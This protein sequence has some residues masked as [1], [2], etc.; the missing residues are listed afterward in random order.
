MLVH[1]AEEDRRLIILAQAGDLDALNELVERHHAW[2]FHLAQRMLWN[3]EDAEDA[4]QEIFI[5]AVTRLAAFEGRSEFRTWLYRIAGNHLL[6]RCRAVKSFDG[7]AR[8]LSDLPDRDLADPNSSRLEASV[9]VEEAKLACTAGI[10]LCLAPRQRMAFLL[11][12]VLGVQDDVGGEVL[13]TS[14]VNF[15]QLL[16]RARRELYGFLQRR[17]GLA[18]PANACRCEN[19]ALGFIALKIVDPERLPFSAARIGEVRRVAADRLAEIRE[20]ERG[21]AEIFRDQPLAPPP[22]QAARLRRLFEQTG[23]QKSMGLNS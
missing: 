5:K 4:T 1:D 13:N 7:M 18:N 14:P 19:K 23:I 11:G 15:R 22:D 17:C 20:V 21:Y 3:R 6:D 2:V 8:T 16:S 10:L 9:L 12:E